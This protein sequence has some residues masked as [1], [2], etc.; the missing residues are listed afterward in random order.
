M[1]LVRD[2]K[3]LSQ[4]AISSSRMAMIAFNSYEDE[5]RITSVLLHLQHAAEMLLKATLCQNK[6][7]VFD[8][9]TG[10]SIGF[11]KCLNLCQSHHGLTEFE[12]GVFRAV[13]KL[14]DEAQHWFIF[15][16]E[17]LLYMHTR[18]T[19]TAFDEY[20]K[21]ALNLDLHSH[22]PARVLPVSTKLPGDFDFLVDREFKAIQE[23]LQPGRRHRDEARARIRSLLAMEAIVTEEVEV[24]KKDINRIERA[25][26]AGNELSAVFPR[27]STINTTESG[28]GPTLKV[29]FSKKQGAPVMFV[30]GDDPAGAAAVREIDL[31]KK[32]HW[33]AT[34]LAQ[35]LGLTP[36]RATALRRHLGIDDDPN[37][38]HV[39][40]F[41]RSKHVCFSDNARDQMKEALDGGIDMDDMW[42][43]HRPGAPAAQAEAAA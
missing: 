20:L 19:V 37:C 2:A 38:R 24:S 36:P 11:E 4:K 33:R 16:S 12:A 32:F 26:K 1:A 6:A 43:N 5:G 18:A 35:S 39:F 15:L 23:L 7:R 21:R 3:T 42:A 34:P 27:L 10:K 14:R 8:K 41:G 25:I 28:E 30:G 13:G 22:I 9:K 40:S 29:H 31:Q 17:E